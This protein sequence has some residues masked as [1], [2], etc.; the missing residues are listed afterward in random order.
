VPR[1][2]ARTTT[3]AKLECTWS[4]HQ[5]GQSEVVPGPTARTARSL[6]NDPPGTQQGRTTSFP[7]D[8]TH[9]PG[10]KSERDQPFPS[11]I[12]LSPPIGRA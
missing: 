7:T 10:F 8:Y 4:L 3:S 9:P 12:S 11:S 2:L 1:E 6:S 5:E